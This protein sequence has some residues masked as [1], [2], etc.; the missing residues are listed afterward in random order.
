MLK[1]AKK[2]SPELRLRRFCPACGRETGDLFEGLCRDCFLKNTELVKG[3]KRIEFGICYDCGRARFN[4]SGRLRSGAFGTP[5]SKFWRSYDSMDALIRDVIARNIKPKHGAKIRANYSEFTVKGKTE[6]PVEIEAALDIV[7]KKLG[8]TYGAMLVILP[9]ICPECSRRRGGYYEA[10]MQLRGSKKEQMQDYI[11]KNIGNFAGEE[12]NAF[13]TKTEKLKEGTD[14]YVGSKE[15]GRRLAG[16]IRKL[17][18]V[19]SSITK[20]I[21]GMKKGKEISRW[22]ILLEDENLK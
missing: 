6:V 8:K 12:E 3:P 4:K 2:T 20:K 9:Q 18:N 22:T 15:A 19:R 1:K 7:A 10:I 13:I 16:Q 21:H 17:Y 11:E 14:V 5:S